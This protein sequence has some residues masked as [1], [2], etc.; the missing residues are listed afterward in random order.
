MQRQRAVCLC[1]H[2]I[3]PMHQHPLEE[4]PRLQLSLTTGEL[5]TTPRSPPWTSIVRR[6]TLATAVRLSRD[7]T[8]TVPATAVRQGKVCSCTIRSHI[9]SILRNRC[10]TANHG[11]SSTD[12]PD[13]YPHL[14][15]RRHLPSI[16]NAI[17]QPSPCLTTDFLRT[18][19]VRPVG[20]SLVVYL[21]NAPHTFIRHLSSQAV[22]VLLHQNE[23]IRGTVEASVVRARAVTPAVDP[24]RRL[25]TPTTTPAAPLRQS[26]LTRMKLVGAVRH[27][28]VLGPPVLAVA[29]T[30]DRLSALPLLPHLGLEVRRRGNT[31]KQRRRCLW[32]RADTRIRARHHLSPRRLL[33]LR[34]PRNCRQGGM[35]RA[36]TMA[37]RFSGEM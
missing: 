26:P 9:R 8:P 34:L 10:S 28:Q 23:W 2:L 18:A 5:P 35:I 20:P 6:C 16:G 19:C 15:F 11:I 14:L 22:R 7:E 12:D 30:M 33:P 21:P 27:P 37:L 24:R 31:G 25:R 1:H 29:S 13:V 17:P 36:L 32:V 4:D 3:F